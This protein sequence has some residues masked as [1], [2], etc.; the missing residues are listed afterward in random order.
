LSENGIRKEWAHGRAIG[1]IMELSD[2]LVD[3]V[4]VAFKELVKSQLE[5]GSLT[6]KDIKEGAPVMLIPAEDGKSVHVKMW[7]LKGDIPLE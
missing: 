3:E 1:E 4:M 5:D 2:E 7:G 6:M